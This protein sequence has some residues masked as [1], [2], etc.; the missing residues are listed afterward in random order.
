MKTTSL[1]LCGITLEIDYKFFKGVSPNYEHPGIP[2]E[3]EIHAVKLG[4]VNCFDLIDP[5]WIE[6]ITNEIL[7]L[8]N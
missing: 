4:T 5:D 2:D 6:Q 8:N 3:V 7:I 1:T